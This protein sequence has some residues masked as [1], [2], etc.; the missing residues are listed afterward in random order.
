MSSTSLRRHLEVLLLSHGIECGVVGMLRVR[1]SRLGAFGTLLD[2]L[3]AAVEEETTGR[4]ANTHDQAPLK[5]VEKDKPTQEGLKQIIQKYF[6]HIWPLNPAM[7]EL[8]AWAQTQTGKKNPWCEHLRWVPGIETPG[9]WEWHPSVTTG[10]IDD[11]LDEHAT[12]CPICG[13]KRPE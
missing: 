4:E 2:D 8:M 13:A 3:V 7:E 9:F 6:G 12:C 10:P 1:P 11:L 5:L